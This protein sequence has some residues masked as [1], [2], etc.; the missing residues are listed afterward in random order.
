MRNG[1]KALFVAMALGLGLN[2]CNYAGV[3]TAGDAAIIARNDNFITFGLLRKIY[4]CKITPGGLTQCA[5]A[6]SP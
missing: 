4:V 5:N 2:A 1:L 6:E 3:A